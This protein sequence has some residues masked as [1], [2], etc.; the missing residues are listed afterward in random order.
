LVANLLFL[1]GWPS[2]GVEPFNIV[3]WS[4]F[5]EMTFYLAFPAVALVALRAPRAGAWAL[6]AAGVGVPVAAAL[7][8]ADPIVLCWS[9]LF[10]GVAAAIHQPRLAQLADRLPGWLVAVAYL[11]VTTLATLLEVPATLAIVA[12]GVVAT[13]VLVKGLRA[14][15]IVSALLTLRPL[16]ALGRVS[17]SFYLLHWMI[18]V[19][20]ARAVD[21]HAHALGVIGGSIVIFSTGFAL[22]FGA[23]QLLW[24]VA[25]RPYLR[26]VQD[27]RGTA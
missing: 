2:L 4:L 21:P 11:T 27:P 9:L 7:G 26:H 22:S 1:N 25:E 23:A 5:Y 17:Y 20:V 13:F 19:L 14:G 8:G 18:V 3:T 16:V 12:F 10:C 15:N 6:P 24:R